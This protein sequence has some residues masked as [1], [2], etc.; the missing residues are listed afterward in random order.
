MPDYYARLIPYLNRP[1]RDLALRKQHLGLYDG[2][3]V[4]EAG[5]FLNGYDMAASKEIAPHL[6]IPVCSPR[7]ASAWTVAPLAPLVTPWNIL[8]GASDARA[9]GANRLDGLLGFAGLGFAN[10]T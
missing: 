7:G 10:V 1:H 9:P 8:R 3:L 2:L 6:M 5:K 4:R